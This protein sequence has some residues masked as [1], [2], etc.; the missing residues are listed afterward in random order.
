VTRAAVLA[1]ILAWTSRAHADAPILPSFDHAPPCEHPVTDPVVTTLRDARLD[2]QRSACMR[3][4]LS[5]GIDAR[6]LIDNPGFHGVLGGAL[7]IGGSVI[8][9]KAHELSAELSL[10]SYEFVQNA[11]NKVTN[12]G[13]GPLVLGAAAGKPIGEHG[14]AALVVRVEVP[15]TRDNV[16]TMHTSAQIAGVVSGM[17]SARTVLHARLASIG[18]VATSAGGT[19]EQLAFIAG[20]DLAWHVRTPVALDLGA[21]VMAGWKASFDHL[22]LRTGVHWR[23][24]GY[25]WRLRVGV[26]IPVAGAERTNA[27]FDAAFVVDR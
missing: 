3:Q 17:L 2:T 13:L 21:D 9:A 7:V 14:T 23:P 12:V 15:Y 10:V 16:D 24:T 26:G 1:L 22:L 11:V 6:A 19:T 27:V 18:S 20:A 8:V 25:A 5:A 4:A